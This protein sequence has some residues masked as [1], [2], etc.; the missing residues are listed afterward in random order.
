MEVVSICELPTAHP[1]KRREKKK[2]KKIKIKIKEGGYDYVRVLACRI[3]VAA[4]VAPEIAR[5]SRPPSPRG[6]YRRWDLS[7]PGWGLAVG[8]PT[9]RLRAVG[10]RKE[11]DEHAK[12]LGG[13]GVIE[14]VVSH[15]QY[16]PG[17]F[18]KST[19]YISFT[20]S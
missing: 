18:L 1:S 17:V 12:Q 3:V 14:R 20:T 10:T 9:C 6:L 2:K 15:L 11:E 13:G 5:I 7:V 8:A 19:R 4:R 16:I